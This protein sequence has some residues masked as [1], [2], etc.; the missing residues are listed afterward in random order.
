MS[1]EMTRRVA[2]YRRVVQSIPSG[3]GEGEERHDEV[4]L[5]MQANGRT[6][7]AARPITGTVRW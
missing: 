1:A 4:A 6:R 5:I 2:H 3:G 7:Y